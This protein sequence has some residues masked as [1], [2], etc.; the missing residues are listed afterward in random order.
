[1]YGAAANDDGY[2]DLTP[3]EYIKIR[4]GDQI[5]YYKKRIVQLDFRLRIFQW[6]IYIMDGIGTFLAALGFKLWASSTFYNI[7]RI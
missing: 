2:R 6:L 3:D 5:S 4:I 7:I 1:M